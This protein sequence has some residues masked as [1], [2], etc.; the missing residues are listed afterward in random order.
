MIQIILGNHFEH[1]TNRWLQTIQDQA[2][3]SFY[4]MKQKVEFTMLI[5]F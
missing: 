5:G 3:S 1:D 2:F 4:S